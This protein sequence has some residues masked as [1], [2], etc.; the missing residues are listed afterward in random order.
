MTSRPLEYAVTPMPVELS[1]GACRHHDVD[2]FF[3]GRGDMHGIARAISICRGCSVTEICL[4]YALESNEPFGI[5]GGMTGKQ[6]RREKRLRRLA[7]ENADLD[8]AE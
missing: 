6:R 2:T 3:P 7:R 5:W 1:E 8:R 4:N